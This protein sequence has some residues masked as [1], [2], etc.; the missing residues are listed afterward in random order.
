MREVPT[1]PAAGDSGADGA[2]LTVVPR[3]SRS[4]DRLTTG[5]AG[6]PEACSHLS[7]E[8]APFFCGRFGESRP[9]RRR[10][11]SRPPLQKSVGH[12]GDETRYFSLK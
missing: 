9:T 1:I 11:G 6:S 5:Q 8:S 2:Q 7:W 10:P 3:D 4:S 12:V